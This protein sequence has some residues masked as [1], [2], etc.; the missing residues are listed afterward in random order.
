MG[1][2]DEY[3]YKVLFVSCLYTETIEQEAKRNGYGIQTAPNTYQWAVVQGLQEN[4]ADYEVVSFPAF[5]C[6]PMHFYR[7][8]VP[9]DTIFYDGKKTGQSIGYSTLPVIKGYSIRRNLHKYVKDWIKRKNLNS[10]DAFAVLIY[11]PNSC[12]VDA[13]IPFKKKYPNMVIATIVT[14]MVDDFF[15]FAS[16]RSTLKRIQLGIETNK[17]K[18]NYHFIDRYILLSKHMEDR[19]PEAIGRNIVVEGIYNGINTSMTV[20]PIP[21]SLLYTGALEEFCGIRQLIEAFSMTK[22]ERFR[23]IICGCGPL[24]GY[25]RKMA[26]LDER[27][28]YRGVVPRAEAIGLQ[29]SCSLLINPRQPDGGITKYSFPSKTMEYLSSGTPMIGY[30]LEG[31]PE[32]YFDYYY[33][34]DD[35]S[36]GTL[37]ST[38]DSLLNLPADDLRSKGAAAKQFILK[39]KTA[40][41]QVRKMLDLIECTPQK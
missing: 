2:N 20:S 37:S 28:E 12:F 38:I 18:H 27:I 9:E 17:V 39:N 14:D 7:K 24:E 23:L 30:K 11:Q 13:V 8:D 29:K 34:L 22:D 16:N 35:L 36:V 3:L 19:I 33:A 21:Y 31:F 40:K 4:H 32:D 10:N 26:S 15:N 1:Q 25:V 6:Y 41:I 5:G